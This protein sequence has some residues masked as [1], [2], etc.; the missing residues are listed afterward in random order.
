QWIAVYAGDAL[1]CFAVWR[2]DPGS[3]RTLLGEL[4]GHPASFPAALKSAL[5]SAHARR[6]RVLNAFTN[7]QRLVPLL[8]ASGFL[9]RSSQRSMTSS[10]PAAHPTRSELDERDFD[11]SVNL[12]ERA[13][14]SRK[15]IAVRYN[16]ALDSGVLL[17]RLLARETPHL[18]VSRGDTGALLAQSRLAVD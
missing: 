7:D 1:R 10:G 5:S 4:V 14:S 11:L 2:F 15:S 3:R 12:A 16:E 18:A 6:A 9:R 17:R 8:K 13:H